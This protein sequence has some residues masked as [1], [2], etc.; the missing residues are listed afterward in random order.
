MTYNSIFG[1]SAIAQHIFIVHSTF[2]KCTIF[3]YAQLRSLPFGEIFPKIW[4]HNFHYP[5]CCGPGVT[6]VDSS[7]NFV[8]HRLLVAAL[9]CYQSVIPANQSTNP[10]R[11]RVSQLQCERI[12]TLW[13][14]GC[15]V[16]Q[17]VGK[18]RGYCGE[19]SP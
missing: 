10:P 1:P 16:G 3:F 19:W 5:C 15:T 14:P 8:I 7:N 11:Y 2:T 18:P 13:T 4:V 6:N 17:S 12:L 9:V